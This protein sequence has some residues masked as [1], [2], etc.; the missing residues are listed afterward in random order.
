MSEAARLRQ[1]FGHFA[2]GVTIVTARDAGGAPVGVTVSS[3]NTVSLSPPLV[4]WSLGRRALS[5]PVFAEA[6]A[7]A[8]HVLAAGERALAERFAC[9]GTDKFAGVALGEGGEGVPLIDAVGTVFECRTV[10]RYDGGDHLI[11][12]GEV[13]D[14]RLPTEPPEPLVFHRGHFLSTAP[15]A[16]EV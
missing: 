14:M 12:V 15:L 6:P 16:Q 7:F 2:T 8:V 11:L 1:A 4:L 3:F 9:A 5:F 10:F 13:T